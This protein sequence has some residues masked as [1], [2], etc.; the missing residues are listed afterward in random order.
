M[1]L[2]ES[3]L[4]AAMW[5]DNECVRGIPPDTN[6]ET[7]LLQ[8]THDIYDANSGKI[9]KLVLDKYSTVLTQ[10]SHPLEALSAAYH[11]LT[12][13]VKKLMHVAIPALTDFIRK[14][15]LTAD[16][17]L[18]A[19][20]YAL[21]DA[22]YGNVRPYLCAC[23]VGPVASVTF[24]KDIVPII[25][26]PLQAPIGQNAHEHVKNREGREA[27]NVGISPEAVYSMP[28]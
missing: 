9:K 17:D 16:P 18:M 15:L 1:R 5:I 12:K 25:A 14:M 8:Y 19:I 4:R 10:K 2:I 27:L 23:H 22:L 13:Q 7:G 21:E 11:E 28:E 20:R 24:V 3:A 6:E 26:Y